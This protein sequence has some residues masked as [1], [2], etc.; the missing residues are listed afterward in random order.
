MDDLKIEL[1]TLENEMQKIRE[2][3]SLEEVNQETSHLEHE[4]EVIENRKRNG[5][6]VSED[7]DNLKA[8]FKILIEIKEKILRSQVKHHESKKES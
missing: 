8:K 1:S 5:H 7:F 4:L 6:D 3:K 2:F